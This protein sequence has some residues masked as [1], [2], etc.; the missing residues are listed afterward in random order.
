MRKSFRKLAL[1]ACFST[2]SPL[3][4]AAGYQ[5]TTTVD[6]EFCASVAVQC[7]V[8]GSGHTAAAATNAN[9]NPIRVFVQ[10]VRANGSP[11][12]GLPV[13]AFTVSNGL[14]PAGGGAA[15]LCSE[16][17]CGV[18]RFGGGSNGTY[19]LILDRIPAGNWKAGAYAGAVQVSDG[20]QQGTAL[21]SFKIPTAP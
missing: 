15:G 9:H 7:L 19:S 12:T 6:T 16:T 3:V 2:L 21:M 17:I 4:L 20:T 14:V 10:V 11:V 8:A 13:T 18:N 5:V 1:L